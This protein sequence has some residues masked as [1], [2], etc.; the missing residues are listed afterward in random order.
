MPANL[1]ADYLDA[2][3]AYKAAKTSDEK[4]VCLQRMLATVPK[5]KGTEKLQADIK[6][7]IAQL[8]DLLERQTR[9]KGPSMR[10][11]PAG[12]GQIALAGPPNS[13]K[14]TFLKQM[15][16][17]EP[18]IADYPFTTRE[19]IP[20]MMHYMDVPIQVLDLPPISPDHS[21]T[22]V[23][24]NI[25][26]ADGV[27]LLLDAAA[28]DPLEDLI[29]ILEILKQKKIELIP[30][31]EDPEENPA[32]VMKIR[33]I[34]ALNKIDLDPQEVIFELLREMSPVVLPIYAIS[35]M[36]NLHLEP[37]RKTVFDL[38]HVIRIYSKE[39]GKEPDL[40]TPFTVPAGSTVMDF[41]ETLHK[42][43]TTRLKAA[44]VWGSA[45]FDGQVV[46]HD[47]ILQ[48]G[49]IVELSI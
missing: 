21:E 36:R 7:R 40:R 14:S 27:I 35:A 5:H 22:F 18:E 12:A 38:L 31:D 41:A 17:A 1:T 46:Q 42:D 29:R 33:A 6:R 16:H 23:F 10:I 20:G 43:F 15:T 4:L 25:R 2:E 37:L 24:D 28:L 32:G 34:V 39:P 45:R 11:K 13:G 8:K 49:D 3:K 30:P 48:D 26:G 9:K 19:P 44:R 47:H